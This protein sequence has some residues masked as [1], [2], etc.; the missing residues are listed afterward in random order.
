MRQINIFFALFLILTI[1][2][3][4]TTQKS[5]DDLSFVGKAYHNTTAHFN[6]Y[7]NANEL[8]ML[9]TEMLKEQHQ[10]NYNKTL[11]IFEYIVAD[12]PQAVAG[13]LDE[14]IK[15]VSLVVNLHRQSDW[16]DDCYLLV[17]KAQFLKQDYE[18][19]EETMRYFVNEFDPSNPGNSK[20]TSK[21]SKSKKGKKKTS[22]SRSKNSK[23]K[24]PSSSGSK[25]KKAKSAAQKRKE[26]NRQVK[27]NKKSRKKSS[28]KKKTPT[29]TPTPEI[30][31]PEK[32]ITKTDDELNPAIEEP[33]KAKAQ[34]EPN[35]Y[36]MKHRP[37][38]Q[39]GVLWLAKTLI[40]RDNFDGAM[41]YMS[42][43]EGMPN[44]F[45]D[46]E[47]DLAP[48]QAYYYYKKKDY[49]QTIAYLEKA[50]E[51]ADKSDPR[52]RYAYIIAQ[53]HQ[54]AGRGD[55]AYAA[56]EEVLKNGP[57]YEMAFSSKVNMA[58]NAYLSGKGNS[59]E[60]KRNLEKMLKDP[61]NEAYKDQ[62]YFALGQIA[63]KEGNREEAIKNL[64]LSLKT[65][66]QNR[67]QKAES[68]LT[69][70]RLY[71]ETE[72]YIPAK[73]YFDST[74]QV[75][76]QTDERY[77]EVQGY[78]NN[79]TEIAQN[80]ET[81]QLQDSLLKIGALSEE[82]KLQLASEIKRKKE[83]EKRKQLEAKNNA[84]NNPRLATSKAFPGGGAGALK[85]E[86]SFFAYDDRKVKRGKKDFLRDWSGRPLEDDWRRSNRRISTEIEEQ[87]DVA[88][89][90][91]PLTPDE[92]DKILT[93]VPKDDDDRA[94]AN[95]QIREA[96]FSLGSLY[97]ER[98]DNNEKAID[99]LEELNRRYPGSN[100]ELD[101]WYFLYLAH[102]DQNNTSKAR[103][104]FDKIVEKY[105]SSTYAMVLKDPDYA[106]KILDEERKLNNYYDE[107]YGAF[108]SGHYREAFEK[109]STAKEKFGA[110]NA[111]QP[112]FA[113]LSAMSTGNLQGQEAYVKA[114]QEVVAKYPNTDENRRA[115]EILRL[116][117]VTTAQLPGQEEEESAEFTLEDD[118]LHYMLVVFTGEG[119]SLTDAKAT[120]SDYNRQ[121]HR[122]DKLRISNIYLGTDVRT[123]IIV[124]RRFKNREEAMRYYNGIEKNRSQFIDRSVPYEVF[125]VT[126][127]NYRQI[128][129]TKSIGGYR[130]FFESNYLK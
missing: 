24:K 94:K 130:A 113:L 41:R 85:V 81:I 31:T 9:S 8:V 2:S 18:A 1:L 90:D 51:L 127:N 13:N 44:L 45:K 23:N 10:D 92:V 91:V 69:L 14:A 82:D 115:K 5:R 38:F 116:L 15:K 37:A 99:I 30:T 48:V 77:S 52:A 110:A 39:E 17:G 108:T 27:K 84:A 76:A 107:A 12:N 43:L 93:G 95:L 88:N 40:E 66:R 75:L 123:P 42:K 55:K 47:K 11:D 26:Y 64:E 89:V 33:K 21:S 53:L 105:P 7:F 32:V 72:D 46:V 103:E 25:K 4:C 74:L 57:D 36:F 71:F 67:S 120:V 128:L 122:L 126:Q 106:N 34:D 118:K 87:Q 62:V 79:L 98:L 61:K 63:L 129:R 60:A 20:R 78:S 83:E 19:A 101:S 119:A 22:T 65:S 100:Y 29:K 28:N 50:L 121:F 49:N 3:A 109:S 58:Q 112:R 97:R 102:T 111:L 80:L 125:A 16:T 35:N 56:F 54:K 124:I 114:L 59:E 117:G 68:Y 73:S 104:Y 86:S 70:A 6:G 96:M